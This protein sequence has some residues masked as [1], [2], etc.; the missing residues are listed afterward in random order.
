MVGEMR[1][2]FYCVAL[3]FFLPGF[4]LASQK[5]DMK[6]FDA[7]PV[8]EIPVVKGYR[9]FDFSQDGKLLWIISEDG[10][11]NCYRIAGRRMM[12]SEDFATASQ[13]LCRLNW[14]RRFADVIRW[15]F[16]VENKSGLK[17]P[18]DISSSGKA[19]VSYFQ[20]SPTSMPTCVNVSYW[21]GRRPCGIFFK[22]DFERC[23]CEKVFSVGHVFMPSFFFS[24]DGQRCCIDN[25]YAT[26][27]L[28]KRSL[29]FCESERTQLDDVDAERGHKIFWSEL[30]A[31]TGDS[32]VAIDKEFISNTKIAI[33]MTSS[34][35]HTFFGRT[36]LLIYDFNLRRIVW[37]RKSRNEFF[38]KRFGWPHYPILSADERYLAV[39]VANTI[40]VYEFP[41]GQ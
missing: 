36:Y 24:E 33:V 31:M 25:M 7:Q 11:T 6:V 4:S 23:F 37:A 16:I 13:P 17:L 38:S 29:L 10:M 8:W 21:E 5:I 30:E 22:T 12:P 14:R 27:P 39:M 9:F 35:R 1:C 40:Y 32:L 20:F 15:E 28:S 18:P 26:R 19:K 2:V 3:V 34:G 41:L